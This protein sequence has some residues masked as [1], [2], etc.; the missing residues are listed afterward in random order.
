MNADPVPAPPGGTN[1]AMTDAL[2]PGSHVLYQDFVVGSSA[3]LLSFDLFIG[4]RGGA[5]VTANPATVGLDFSTPALN[6]QARIDIVKSTADPF[7]VATSDVLL[8]LYQT[9]PGDPLVAGYNTLNFDLSALF[10]ANP[11]QTLRLR[12][13]E[14]DNLAQLQLGVDNVSLEALEAVPEPA[15]LVL[16]R[17]RPRRVLRSAFSQLADLYPLKQH[18]LW[19]V[20][21]HMLPAATDPPS[22]DCFLA[23]VSMKIRSAKWAGLASA[24]LAILG[25]VISHP[26]VT[27]ADTTPL[28]MLD[29]NLQAE[30]ILTATNGLNQPIGIVF[31][32]SVNDYLVL[33][34]ASG[35][36][37]RVINGLVQATPVLDLP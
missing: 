17:N 10:A 21:D 15:S 14:T 11:G 5:F 27:R 9:K 28:T 20:A 4:N 36:V 3:A 33:E 1:A 2:G 13:A 25:V 30:A 37:K 18:R 22:H 32:G 6:E 19:P 34:K 29:P 16:S 8:N 23:E 35:Q 31:L 26:R 12:F 24:G 7:S